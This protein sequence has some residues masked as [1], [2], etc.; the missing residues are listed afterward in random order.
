M[1]PRLPTPAN[2]SL[3]TADAEPLVFFRRPIRSGSLLRRG[4]TMSAVGDSGGFKASKQEQDLLVLF[5]RQIRRGSSLRRGVSQPFNLSAVLFQSSID[6]SSRSRSVEISSRVLVNPQLAVLNRTSWSRSV[7]RSSAE[8]VNPVFIA[9]NWSSRSRS[10]ESTST[11]LVNQPI[12]CVGENNQS[13]LWILRVLIAIACCVSIDFADKSKWRE[14]PNVTPTEISLAIPITVQLW[15]AKDRNGNMKPSDQQRLPGRLK[16][17]S[18]FFIQSLE[19]G[20]YPGMFESRGLVRLSQKSVTD[21][22]INQFNVETKKKVELLRIDV[23]IDNMS[24]SYGST[25]EVACDSESVSSGSGSF[26]TRGLVMVSGYKC[27]HIQKITEA[28][29]TEEAEIESETSKIAVLLHRFL[30]LQ[31]CRAQAYARLKMGFEDYMVLGVESAYQKLCSKIAV[32]FNDCSKQV[33]EMESQFLSPDCFI[34]DLAALPR[35]VQTQEKQKLELTA[36]TQALKIVSHENCRFS[37]PMGHECY[38]YPAYE[39]FKY[40]ELNKPDIQ[41]LQFWCQYWI[42]VATMTA[43]EKIADTSILWVPILVYYL[44]YG[45]VVSSGVCQFGEKSASVVIERMKQKKEESNL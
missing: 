44:Q 12:A 7:K 8:L 29:G 36:T 16:L 43:C 45:H 15:P 30:A 22:E 5:R 4:A 39:C 19:C 40:V 21:D 11:A 33:L 2:R 9:F 41:Q 24:S 17:S 23:L 31:Q 34:E 25:E 14:A 42:I 38:A 13:S 28:S 35:F 37:K 10:V 6:G 1:P 26:L 3:E 18:T 27:V 32:E 20:K